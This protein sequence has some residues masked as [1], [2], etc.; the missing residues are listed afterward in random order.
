MTEERHSYKQGVWMPPSR[1]DTARAFLAVHF[2]RVAHESGAKFGELKITVVPPPHDGAFPACLPFLVV[3]E[4]EVEKDPE[5]PAG[6][7]CETEVALLE[8]LASTLQ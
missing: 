7:F 3:G 5:Q 6:E 8:S 2:E 1:L 4:A